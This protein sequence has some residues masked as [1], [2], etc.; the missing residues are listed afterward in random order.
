MN[1]IRSALKHGDLLLFGM[2]GAGKTTLLRSLKDEISAT[3]KDRAVYLDAAAMRNAAEFTAG[4]VE[5][6]S[7]AREE[8]PDILRVRRIGP[9]VSMARPEIASVLRDLVHRLA[10]GLGRWTLLVD[11]LDQFLGFPANGEH[12]PDF[13][14][15]LSSLR[16]GSQRKNVQWVF[17]ARSSLLVSP[18][19]DISFFLNDLQL[20]EIGGMSEKETDELIS[21]LGDEHGLKLNAKV[22]RLL[23]D[24]A[25]GLP[26][27]VRLLVS[28]LQGEV[29]RSD[30]PVNVGEA[31]KILQ[32]LTPSLLRRV[33]DPV[34]KELVA[35]LESNQ[36]DLARSLVV[37]TARNPKGIELVKID[38][39]G[40]LLPSKDRRQVVDL[41]I[42]AGFLHRSKDRVVVHELFRDYFEEMF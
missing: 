16:R 21:H 32:R 41:L 9:S 12:V 40:A 39:I 22:R 6:V 7:A 23:A 38:S 5:A 15:T 37:E 17:A 24:G 25:Q 27:L 36:E 4:L 2:A 8:G 14:H 20:L 3:P 10:Q 1:Q 31:R 34:W 13:L 11:H 42:S 35:P 28:A 19:I 30:K 33:V 26:L 29:E 18:H